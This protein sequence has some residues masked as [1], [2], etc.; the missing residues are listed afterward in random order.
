MVLDVELGM[1]QQTVLEALGKPTR[2]WNT[3]PD[4]K[5]QTYLW[6]SVCFSEKVYR[7]SIVIKMHKS[8]GVARIDVYHAVFGWT[9]LSTRQ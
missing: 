4:G 5:A 9:Y 3:S 1:D 2:Q 8:D 6:E 7:R